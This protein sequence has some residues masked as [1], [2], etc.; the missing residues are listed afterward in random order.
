MLK[1][2]IWYF[3]LQVDFDRTHHLSDKEIKRRE[4]DKLKAIEM[5]KIKTAQAV[6]EKDKESKQKEIDT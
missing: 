1:T 2:N 3:G 5:E 6:K 4:V